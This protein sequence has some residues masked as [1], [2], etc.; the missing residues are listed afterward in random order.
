MGNKIKAFV[1]KHRI[2]GGRVAALTAAALMMSVI[3]TNGFS[4]SG[5]VD[6]DAL[7]ADQEAKIEQLQKDNDKRKQQISSY[8]GSISENEEIM[9]VISDQIDGVN[10]EILAYGEKITIKQN[11]I[12]DKRI[13]IV[14]IEQSIA[15]KEDEIEKKSIEI[16]QLHVENDLNLERFAKLA[17]ALYMYDPS[18]TIPLLNG[19]D[20]WYNFFVYSDVIQNISGQNFDFMN[21]L[22][23]DIHQQ[24]QMIA[25]LDKEISD[26]E[27]QKT[28]LEK[29]KADL[30]AKMTE[31]EGEKSDLETYKDAQY[32]DLYALAAENQTLSDKVSNLRYAYNATVEEIEQAN[33]DIEEIIRQK[34]AANSGQTVY[35]SNGFRWPLDANFTYLTTYFGYDSWRGGNHYGID[36]GNAGIGGQNIYAA[37]SGTVITAYNDGSWHGGYGNYVVIDHGGGLS[38]LYAHC[39]STAV[40]EGQVVNKGDVIGYVGQ[41]GWATGNHLHFEVRVNGVATDP[42]GYEYEYIY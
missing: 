2:A 18:E 5:T 38:T 13:E 14:N 6:Y 41:T 22:L 36:V 20:D 31:L 15:D 33:K 32:N 35:S 10:S 27:K 9:S 37:Q 1:K 16:E 30:E 26:L 34:Q 24:E 23:D 3:S 42:L 17:R 8:N 40:S 19:S 29:E 28:D 7:I 4:V 25:D 12:S 21:Q 39:V 11:E